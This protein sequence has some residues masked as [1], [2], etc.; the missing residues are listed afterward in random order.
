METCLYKSN[1]KSKQELD[2]TGL[3]VIR[4]VATILRCG[5]TEGIPGWR[6]LRQYSEMLISKS[7]LEKPVWSPLHSRGREQ[8]CF[9]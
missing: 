1:C 3:R 7:S 4:R 8:S 5:F 9:S 2:V 6:S